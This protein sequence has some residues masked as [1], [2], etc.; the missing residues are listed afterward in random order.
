[1]S[2]LFILIPFALILSS[3]N[4]FAIATCDTA[5]QNFKQKGHAAKEK[6]AG[7]KA[8]VVAPTSAASAAAES[9]M[10]QDANALQSVSTFG[11]FVDQATRKEVYGLYEMCTSTCQET[12]A[13]TTDE[14]TRAAANFNLKDCEASYKVLN[15]ELKLSMIGLGETAIKAAKVAAVVGGAAL[16][17]NAMKGSDSGG[18]AGA[19]TGAGA[20][21]G[22]GESGGEAPIPRN[23]DGTV[24]CQRVAD[25]YNHSD[26]DS[27]YV[28]HCDKEPKGTGCEQFSERY[29]GLENKDSLKIPKGDT[30]DVAANQFGEFCK[31][32]MGL[33]YCEKGGREQCPT[34]AQ[35]KTRYSPACAS[36]PAACMSPVSREVMIQAQT[37]CPT[38]PKFSDPEIV[39][40][41]Q[42]P[43]MEYGG[44]SSETAETASNSAKG[45]SLIGNSGAG[46]ASGSSDNKDS[47]LGATGSAGKSNTKVA[48]TEIKPAHSVS[49]LQSQNQSVQQLCAENRLN[50]CGP[51][52]QMRRPSSP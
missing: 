31:T 2:K 49:L 41:I 37:S 13:T 16:V 17:L 26:C 10:R 52:A 18:E 11:V 47:G 30:T 8:S 39:R 32:Q 6:N 25:P 51:Q 44:S 12:A 5:L 29:C 7:A 42:D 3:Q 48:S 1:M 46:V 40:M 15:T 43:S 27:I 19:P 36:N 22:A 38:D 4:A 20:G 14:A 24:N 9:N 34:C 45:G 35:L 23:A 50:Q 21:S 28:E 33:R